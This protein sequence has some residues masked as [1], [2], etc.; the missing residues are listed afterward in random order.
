MKKITTIIYSTYYICC[1]FI[2]Y[3]LSFFEEEVYIDGK[4]IKNACIA[5]RALVVDDIRDITAPIS[6]LFIIPLLYLA[7][8]NK[9]KSLPMN[10]MSFSLL[11]Y[12]GW[13]FFIRLII[14]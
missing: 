1:L 12:W 9:F 7:I 13:R 3:L 14:C 5:H 10:I 6:I 2:I 4:E 11:A 8:R